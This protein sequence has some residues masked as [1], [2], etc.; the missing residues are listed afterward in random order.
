MIPVLP[1][2][3]IRKL[4]LFLV[5]NRGAKALYFLFSNV[6]GKMPARFLF[7]FLFLMVRAM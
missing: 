1:T 6:A 7:F 2:D 3:Q 5:R 4:K